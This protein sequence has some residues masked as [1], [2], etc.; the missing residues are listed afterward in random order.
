MTKSSDAL[1][2]FRCLSNTLYCPAGNEEEGTEA[3]SAAEEEEEDQPKSRRRRRRAKSSVAS[4]D[5]LRE[6]W[7]WLADIKTEDKPWIFFAM[8]RAYHSKVTAMHYARSQAFADIC[9]NG[10]QYNLKFEVQGSWL[11]T[12]FLQPKSSTVRMTLPTWYLVLGVALLVTRQGG[13]KS[14]RLPIHMQADYDKAWD[15]LAEGNRLQ[16]DTYTFNPQVQ[17]I[18]L[19]S[20]RLFQACRARLLCRY[21]NYCRMVLI[22]RPFSLLL[23]K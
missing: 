22:F 20:C 6:R 12:V 4:L 8:H 7:H 16:R 9:S 11:R 14:S 18:P 13:C 23:M 21:D 2:H 10:L 19:L 17:L 1:Q 5:Q 3:V 15:Y